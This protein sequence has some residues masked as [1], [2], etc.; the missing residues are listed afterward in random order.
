[1]VTQWR[2]L[3]CGHNWPAS[4][5]SAPDLRLQSTLKFLIN[6]HGKHHVDFLHHSVQ[7]KFTYTIQR[8]A[9]LNL[10]NYFNLK[11]KEYL[12]CFVSTCCW[13]MG[14]LCLKGM[15][16]SIVYMYFEIEIAIEVGIILHWIIKETVSSSRQQSLLLL[17]SL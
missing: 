12:M 8:R 11:K 15:L 6:L 14:Q 3:Y 13:E 9:E 7:Y 17:L 4:Q 16:P 2:N 10:L 5:K 1:M